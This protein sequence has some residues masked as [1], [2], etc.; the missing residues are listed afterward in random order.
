MQIFFAA[1]RDSQDPIE[2]DK[3][4]DVGMGD[5]GVADFQQISGAKGQGIAQIKDDRPVFKKKRNV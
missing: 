5:E 1:Q 4:I 3:M 2:A